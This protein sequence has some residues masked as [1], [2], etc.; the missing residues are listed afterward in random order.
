MTRI[1]LKRADTHDGVLHHARHFAV[2]HR[3]EVGE[4]EVWVKQLLRS[5]MLQVEAHAVRDAMPMDAVVAVVDERRVRLEGV[6]ERELAVRVLATVTQLQ[7]VAH[8]RAE[9]FERMNPLR[10]VPATVAKCEELRERADDVRDL[11]LKLVD[12]RDSAFADDQWW[13]FCRGLRG[14]GSGLL[15][16]AVL[17]VSADIEYLLQRFLAETSGP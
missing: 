12:R 15:R 8:P 6:P 9:V 13:G 2:G 10:V 7:A 17:H 1:A 14:W 16:L 5:G 3:L 4:L 11:A